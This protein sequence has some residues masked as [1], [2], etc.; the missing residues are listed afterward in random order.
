VGDITRQIW[1]QRSESSEAP[2]FRQVAFG[3]KMFEVAYDTDRKPLDFEVKLDKFDIGFER[4]TEQPTKFVSHVRLTDTSLGVSDQPHTISMNVPLTHR[5]F[6]FYQSRYSAIPD[7]H[8][9]ESTGQFQSVL[10]VGTDPARPVKYAGC[11]VIVLGIFVQ[12][13]MRAGVFTD[14]GKR[15]RERALRREKRDRAAGAVSDAS[16]R[17]VPKAGEKPL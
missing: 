15:Q 3:D 16:A 9:G 1:I 2:S 17:T 14:G 10:Q 7:P 4:G 11:L 12:F 6:T 8:T 5:G 13:Y